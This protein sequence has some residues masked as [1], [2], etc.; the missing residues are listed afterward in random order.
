[1][2]DQLRHGEFAA[3][4]SVNNGGYE[5][6]SLQDFDRGSAVELKAYPWPTAIVPVAMYRRVDDPFVAQIT[7]ESMEYESYDP[8]SIPGL[9][10]QFSRVG[11]DP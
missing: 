11:N 6:V 3:L 1:M 8:L 10:R 7:R 4:W 9:H 2:I 5:L